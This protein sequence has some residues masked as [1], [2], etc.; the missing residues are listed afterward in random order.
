MIQTTD[1]LCSGDCQCYCLRVIID[2][3]CTKDPHVELVSVTNAIAVRMT[4]T[5]R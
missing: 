4:G 3:Y 2:I 5:N 1:N